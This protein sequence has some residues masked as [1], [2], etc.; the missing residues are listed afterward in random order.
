MKNFYHYF[1]SNSPLPFPNTTLSREV[2]AITINEVNKKVTKALKDSEY[3]D[4]GVIAQ[5]IDLTHWLIKS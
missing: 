3:K 5:I 1:K 4:G 2:P